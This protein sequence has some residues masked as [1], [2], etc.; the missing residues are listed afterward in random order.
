MGKLNVYRI[1][2]AVNSGAAAVVDEVDRVR[3]AVGDTCYL[4]L[5]ELARRP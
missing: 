2:P 4:R 3:R 5:A 1:N